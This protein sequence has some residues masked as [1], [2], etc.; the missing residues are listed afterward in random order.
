VVSLELLLPR[1]DRFLVIGA[2]FVPGEIVASDL[3]YDGHIER[4]SRII[5][6]EGLLSNY[7]I[8]HSAIGSSRQARYALK[9]RACE[10]S[11]EYK[12]GEPALVRT[13]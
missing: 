10:V 4:K 1:G 3:S 6:S 5:S 9:G 7:V 13:R 11:V 2:G 8:V 12:W